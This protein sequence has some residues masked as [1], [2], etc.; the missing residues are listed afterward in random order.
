MSGTI[1]AEK[2]E[3]YRTAKNTNYTTAK[4]INGQGLDLA[5]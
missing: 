1:L 2:V 4:N 5:H 3:T